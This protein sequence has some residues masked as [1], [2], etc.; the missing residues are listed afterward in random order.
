MECKEKSKVI[1]AAGTSVLIETS[2]N[3]KM[4]LVSLVTVYVAVLIETSWN[5]KPV[6]GR[7]NCE[8]TVY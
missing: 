5:V 6:A 2:W 8:T 3:V 7:T 1:F 4:S